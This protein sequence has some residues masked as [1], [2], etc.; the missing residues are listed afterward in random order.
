M[1]ATHNT[2]RYAAILIPLIWACATHA[3]AQDAT[4]ADLS[5]LLS[6]LPANKPDD[7]RPRL[8]ALAPDDIRN[9]CA[10]LHAPG[11]G[12]DT[13]ARYALNGLAFAVTA[14][15]AGPARAR[16]TE[17]LTN[18]L[19]GDDPGPDPQFLVAQLSLAGNTSA[20]AA[21]AR[22]LHNEHLCQ[23]AI[24]ALLSSGNT[25]APE[26]LRQA[27]PELVGPNRVA[28]ILALGQ[29]NDPQV[30]PL[31]EPFLTSNDIDLRSAARYAIARSGQPNLKETLKQ[32]CDATA[33][34]E[35][36]RA[37]ADLLVYARELTHHQR[38]DEARWLYEDLLWGRRKP[39]ELHIR[40]AAISGLALDVGVRVAL[41]VLQLLTDSNLELRATA[42]NGMVAMAGNHATLSC[43]LGLNRTNAAGQVAILRVLAR[44]GDR[45]GF[46]IARSMLK[47]PEESVVAAALT[48][49]ATIDGTASTEFLIERLAD[50]R[51]AVRNTAH[52]LLINVP[53]PETTTK[54]N[55]A[56]AGATP[57]V[58]PLL[59]DI[60]ASRP[61]TGDTA[62]I[63]DATKSDDQR[64]R[65]AAAR[66]L[67]ELAGPKALP[68][69]LDLLRETTAENQRLPIEHACVTIAHRAHASS[70]AADQVAN[71]CEQ[72][73]DVGLRCSL[74]RIL[75]QLG[76]P[77]ALN[78]VKQ[79]LQ[80]PDPALSEQALRALA[81]WPD[82]G[83]L[84][85]AFSIARAVSDT[86]RQVLALRAAVRMINLLDVPAEMKLDRF[87]GA[88]NLAHRDEE[89]KLILARVG[90]VINVASLDWLYPHLDAPNLRAEAAAATL[91]VARHLLPNHATQVRVAL[92]AILLHENLPEQLRT[93]A[94][95]LIAEA[96][97]FAGYISEWWLAGPYTRPGV[98]GSELI[99]IPFPPEQADPNVDWHEISAAGSPAW[100]VQLHELIPGDDRAAYLAA[101]IHVTREQPA[102][103]QV[104]SDDDIKIWLN[105][106][107]V[108]RNPVARGLSADSERDQVNVTL[109][110]GWN[111]LLLK[112]INRGGGWGA[113]VRVCTP[114]GHPFD[115]LHAN[116]GPQPGSEPQPH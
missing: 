25:K 111:D 49:L 112:V 78:I 17:T 80:S 68:R 44:R 21:L 95:E 101:R 105:G 55:A 42:E 65:T 72:T 16:F 26:L 77:R 48:A 23:P 103:L 58:Q 40:C 74:L 33:G 19:L 81:D 11:A 67:G 75:G 13:Q 64:V 66:A 108:H 70:T 100:A 22:L 113:A 5:A 46:N 28:A 71:A 96:Q 38:E 15:G 31:V 98:P 69:L 34:F 93:Q 20:T 104:G 102:L 79:D 35:H 110:T 62:P 12:G 50:Q 109:Q 39:D 61:A 54:I 94:S 106:T 52:H 43:G 82:A 63:L 91:N 27:L 37:T 107:V 60:L 10:Q 3:E 36:M 83:P 30:V 45:T 115:D 86:K 24:R 47:K 6:E 57:D 56:L 114:D 99:D 29:L 9:L 2:L 89:R 85:L 7:V 14:P 8:L 18:I 88:F 1:S 59:L 87:T 73:D 51:T 4:T 41:D 53:G 32:A 92:D 116:R 97:R 84:E 90:D 76:G